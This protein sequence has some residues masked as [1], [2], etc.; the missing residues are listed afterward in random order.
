MSEMDARLAAMFVGEIKQQC[1]FALLAGNNLVTAANTINSGTQLGEHELDVGWLSIQA[2]LIS[3]ANVSKI[4]WPTTP[5]KQR[6]E[7]EVQFEERK[8]R[9]EQRGAYLRRILNVDEDSILESRTFRNHF[10]HIDERIEKWFDSYGR[11]NSAI[12]GLFGPS[13]GNTTAMGDYTFK[14]FDTSIFAVTFRGNRFDLKPSLDAAHELLNKTDAVI[15]QLIER[16]HQERVKPH[17]INSD[18]TEAPG[19]EQP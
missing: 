4:L 13:Y 5:S 10:E 6:R 3:L 9:L 12:S 18:P 16:D 8:R 19:D 1:T 15:Q 7:D 17:E 14:G 11:S 2:V